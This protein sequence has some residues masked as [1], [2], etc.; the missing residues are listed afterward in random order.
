MII[1]VALLPWGSDFLTSPEA[2]LSPQMLANEE[3]EACNGL[4]GPT[5][6]QEQRQ[7]LGR[8]S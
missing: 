2:A 8:G 3:S 5:S 6:G 4:L 1:S 7:K